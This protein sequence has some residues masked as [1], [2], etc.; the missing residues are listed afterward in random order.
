MSATN[1]ALTLQTTVSGDI[2]INGA[3]SL[4][5]QDA[6]TFAGTVGLNG[7]T[8]V[9]TDI[10][11]TLAGTENIAITSD[12]AGTVNVLSLIT[13]PSASAGTTRGF[14]IQQASSANTNGLDAALY[15]DN[16]DDGLAIPAAISIQNSGG[17]GY[18]AVIDNAGTLISGAEL[19]LLDGH[20][21]ALVDTNDAVATA[22]TGTGALAAGSL[23]AGFTTVAVGQGGTGATT[24]TANGVLYGNTTGAVL[25][26][27][28]GTTGQCLTG[29][30]GA[31]PAW[32]ACT[33]LV[34]LQN[35]YDNGNT[36]TTSDARNITLTY[37]D[38][39]TDANLTISTA[40]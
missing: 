27:A 15:I 34:T 24:F 32:T 30:T 38:T 10:D 17:G 20:D 12:L 7:V 26:T 21:V 29:A 16:A 33:C 14:F 5:V 8:T 35:A 1:A 22:I 39:A 9:S 13:T 25:V 36:I 2:V 31:A 6:A 37:A 19:N 28:A 3:G 18:T 4:D 40:T 23:A 11:L